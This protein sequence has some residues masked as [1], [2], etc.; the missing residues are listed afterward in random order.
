MSKINISLNGS[1]FELDESVLASASA[2]IKSHLSTV[3]NGEGA[4]IK[5]D[6]VDYSID[7][8]KLSAATNDFVA[9]LGTIAG[10]GTKIRIGDIEYSVD[11]TKISGAISKLESAFG[12]LSTP[13][14]VYSEGLEFTSN[15]DGTCYVSGI[16]TCTDTDIV[17]PLTSPEGDSV[18]SIGEGAFA[19]YTYLSSVVIGDSVT[20][21]EYGAFE[22]CE[23]LSSVVIGDSVTSIGNY[24][25]AGCTSITDITFNGTATQ[26]NAVDLS[27]SWNR[28]VPAT[29]VHCI[30]GD[31]AL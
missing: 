4:T 28:E 29:H 11:S 31:V 10:E 7:S 1:T 21:I 30:D 15:G 25:F 3:M 17:I 9:Y 22:G 14:V 6:G 27:S 12:A 8:T 26:W 2:D 19:Y 13:E 23:S 20:S 16:G 18:T 24:A 5:F